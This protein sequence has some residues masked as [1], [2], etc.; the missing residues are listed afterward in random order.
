MRRRVRITGSRPP[1]PLVIEE[2]PEGIEER[3][4]FTGR[5]APV[6]ETPWVGRM[7]RAGT[8]PR[9]ELLTVCGLTA[10]A[11]LLAALLLTPWAGDGPSPLAPE[12]HVTGRLGADRIACAG[13]VVTVRVSGVR[14]SAGVALA[15][16]E[17][18]DETLR[19]LLDAVDGGYAGRFIIMGAAAAPRP[20][21]ARERID[22][23][24]GSTVLVRVDGLLQ[25][26]VAAVAGG[27]LPFRGWGRTG[28]R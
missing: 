13:D 25:A 6:G 24:P 17:S 27:F 26:R 15:W 22:L 21:T 1:E 11:A 28:C 3:E 20:G 2:L 12:L 19:L 7:R 14:P 9:L 16:I 18:G 4:P 8:A 10:L 5:R 23:T